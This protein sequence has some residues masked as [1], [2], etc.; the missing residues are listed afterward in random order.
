MR[1]PIRRVLRPRCAGGTGS[2]CPCY[3]RR[4]PMGDVITH[5][6]MSLDGFIADPDD[7]CDEPARW[8]SNAGST[9]S[10]TA[11]TVTPAARCR[12]SWS[13]I[14][15]RRTG[16]AAACRSGLLR[17]LGRGRGREGPRAG[18]HPRPGAPLRARGG[19]GPRRHPP[20]L[21]HPQ[22]AVVSPLSVRKERINHEQ[23]GAVYVDV[24]RRVRR[25]AERGTGQ[26]TH[27][28]ARAG[29]VPRIPSSQATPQDTSPGRRRYVTL[30]IPHG[31][32]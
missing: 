17:D 3:S 2:V 21:R 29:W 28:P 14:T 11:G 25:R 6:A 18:R 12:W 20:A 4:C 10:P 23:D 7:G 22:G 24:R 1:D 9:T 5:L 26:R 15:R 27:Q 19:R 16:R 8:W 32:I 30:T 31:G 13:P